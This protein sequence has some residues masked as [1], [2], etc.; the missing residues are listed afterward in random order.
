VSRDFLATN[1]K[2]IRGLSDLDAH[3]DRLTRMATQ[4]ALIGDAK[5]AR[6]YATRGLNTLPPSGDAANRTDLEYMAAIALAWAGDP[7]GAVQQLAQ[8]LDA[9]AWQKPASVWCD[10]YL[11]PLRSDPGFR[12][13]LADHG[14]NL[15]IDP[16]RRET[17]PKH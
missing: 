10:P 4:Y 16:L 6:E 7:Q 15:S 8:M 1:E 12:K 11:A 13:L 2:T 3:A 14:A 5:Q 9:P 17:W